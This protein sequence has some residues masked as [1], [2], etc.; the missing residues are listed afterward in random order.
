MDENERKEI[1]S[2]E[3][4]STVAKEAA[5][6]ASKAVLSKKSKLV[7]IIIAAASSIAGAAIITGV[8]LGSPFKGKGTDSFEK[9][10]TEIRVD[11]SQHDSNSNN[12]ASNSPIICNHD[13]SDWDTVTPATCK[14]SGELAR[15]C[16]KC[17]Q[18][19]TSIIPKITSHTEVIDPAISATCTTDGMTEGKHCSVCNETIVAPTTIRKLNH[20]EVTD[21]AISATCTTNGKTEGTHCDR[22]KVVLT[23]Q[24]E[25]TSL[26]HQYNDG[27]I[28]TQAACNQTGIK[29]FTCLVQSCNHSYTETYS[30]PTYSATELYD[31][32]VKYVGEIVTYNRSGSEL[33]LGTGFVISTDGKIVTNYHVIDGAYSA[34][35]TI[36]GKKYTITSV[37]AYDADIDLAILKVN[38][39]GLTAATVCKK[40]VSVGS[41]VYAIGSSRGMTNTY[42]QGIVTYA[43]RVVD[44][45]THIQHDASITHGNSGGPLINVYGEV[46]GINTWGISDS[47]NLNF[48][49]FTSE[50]DNLTYGTPLTFVEFYLKECSVF[51]RLKNYIIDN[52][53]YDASDNTYRFVLGTTYSSDYSSK[54]TRVAYYYANSNTITLDYLI[55]DGDYWV[56]FV[57]DENV[58]GSYAWS[59]FDDDNYKMSGTLYASTYGSGTLLSYSSNNISYSSLRTV[60]RKLASQMVNNLCLWL[61]KD[62]SSINV[63][64]EDL[65]FY[66]Y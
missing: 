5:K 1:K 23:P 53:S 29:T 12:D 57:I 24:T 6:V 56:Y 32:S 11:T 4:Q 64:A 36:N 55:D 42:S 33:A 63:T 15:V 48:A 37:L 61:D 44:G 46:V 59:Y 2:E 52:G 41:T 66:N 26:G 21:P 40:A 65:G 3:S 13:F 16:S 35:I 43:N 58:D 18:T 62:F 28:T 22:C 47:Q 34:D 30:L 14:E 50:L 38:A 60:V 27:V 51:E 8:I 19:E 7:P 9:Q 54:Y 39:T 31:L 20:V 25:I 49:V 17:A 10:E 45:V